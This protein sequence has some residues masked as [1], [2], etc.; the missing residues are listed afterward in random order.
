MVIRKFGI[1]NTNVPNDV[2]FYGIPFPGDYLINPDGVVRE[3]LFLPDYQERAAASQVVLKDFGSA[4]DDNGVT[5]TADDV[6]AKISLSGS[7]NFSGNEIGV[8][9]DFT[10]GPGWHIYGR[11]LPE[12]YTPTAVKFDDAL[13]SEQSIVFPKPTPVKFELL[14]ET[15]PVYQGNFKAIGTLR[16]KQKLPPGDH[17]LGGT[18]EFQEC[19]DS[20]CKMP[21]TAHFEIPIKIE[22][23]TPGTPKS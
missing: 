4:I 6:E 5:V 20:L 23:L 10:V 13:V 7:H 9:V 11:P 1:L 19:N 3:K 16:L 14:G 15:L 17:T 2:M 8:M 21:R 12:G 18:L 22:A